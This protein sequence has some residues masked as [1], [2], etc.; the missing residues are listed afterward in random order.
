MPQQDIKKYQF[1]QKLCKLPYVDTIYLFG[2][3][4]TDSYRERSDIDLAI[5]CPNA[6]DSQWL[7]LLSVIEEADTLLLIDCVRL[8]SL[9]PSALRTEIERTKHLLYRKETI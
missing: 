8:D 9:P 3:R 2:S 7:A 6:T 1:F 4:A 5:V